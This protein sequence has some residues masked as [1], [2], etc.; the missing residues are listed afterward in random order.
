MKDD[1]HLKLRLKPFDLLV[2]LF[3]S[4]GSLAELILHCSFESLS[5]GFDSLLKTKKAFGVLFSAFI[6]FL[7]FLLE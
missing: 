5:E 6:K 7:Q 2:D 4:F 1:L 3:E